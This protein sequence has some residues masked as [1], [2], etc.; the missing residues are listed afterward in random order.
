MHECPFFTNDGILTL[1]LQFGIKAVDGSMVNVTDSS[2]G[3]NK[4]AVSST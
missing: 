3:S 4:A 2:I 1:I